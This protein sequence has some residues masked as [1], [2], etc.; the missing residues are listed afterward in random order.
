M[1]W[2]K[3]GGIVLISLTAILLLRAYK[4]EWAV[5]LRMGAMVVCLGL[6][7][8]LMGQAVTYASELTAMTGG[9]DGEAWEMLLKALG[10]AFLTEITASICRDS[11]EGGLATWVETAGRLE[12]LLL[13]FPL[14]RRIMDIVVALLKGV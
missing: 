8:D 4:P 10:L 1:E 5:L 3:I 13:S 2:F 11:G 7:L 9:V 6:M 14:I 12:I